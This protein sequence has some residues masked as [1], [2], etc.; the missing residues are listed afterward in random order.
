MN[1]LDTAIAQLADHVG[2]DL[3]TQAWVSEPAWLDA[4]DHNLHAFLRNL[5]HA[6]QQLVN[7]RAGLVMTEPGI[8]KGAEFDLNEMVQSLDASRC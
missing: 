6:H 7:A 3:D 8:A 5:F 4:A 1:E 2:F